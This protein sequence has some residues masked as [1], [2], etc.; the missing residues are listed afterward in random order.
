MTSAY[1]QDPW[2]CRMNLHMGGHR[3]VKCHLRAR[4]A[5]RLGSSVIGARRR[6]TML[7][8]RWI[9]RASFRQTNQT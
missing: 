6:A 3:P 9:R 5:P 8:S 2:P 7:R 4:S 1:S